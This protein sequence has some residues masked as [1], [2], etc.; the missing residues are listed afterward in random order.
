MLAK[1]AMTVDEIENLLRPDGKRPPFATIR[2]EAN[3]WV[4]DVAALTCGTFVLLHRLLADSWQADLAEETAQALVT[5]NMI[6]YGAGVSGERC[7]SDWGE[8]RTIE[9]YENVLD[10]ELLIVRVPRVNERCRPPVA[11]DGVCR[12]L[13]ANRVAQHLREGQGGRYF[14]ARDLE[15]ARRVF[16]ARRCFSRHDRRGPARR[17]AAHDPA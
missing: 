4:I 5:G 12:D 9:E 17:L 1:G 15:V 14:W 10:E 16:R 6:D 7:V 13:E 11:H 2:V 8:I 3:A